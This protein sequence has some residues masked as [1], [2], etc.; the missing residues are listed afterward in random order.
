[1]LFF[2]FMI[3][4]PPRAT[5]PDTLCP[6]TTLFRY[7]GPLVLLGGCME[8]RSSMSLPPAP[9]VAVTAVAETEAV[10]T[11]DAD[12]ADDPAIWRNADD[13]QASLLVAT[14]KKAG[15]YV[16]RSEESRG[17]KACV[18]TCRSRWST[19]H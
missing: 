9:T 11:R 3:R 17:G 13:P 1:M 19:H 15:L 18:G 7:I 16:Y 4:R 14:D 8:G 2:F 6:Y 12:A 5:R 10:A